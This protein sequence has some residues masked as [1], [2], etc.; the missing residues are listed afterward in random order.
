MAGESRGSG[1]H[2]PALDILGRRRAAEKSSVGWNSGQDSKR[3]Y[4]GFGLGA[5]AEKYPRYLFLPFSAISDAHEQ[6]WQSRGCAVAEKCTRTKSALARHRREG[7]A[8]G[9]CKSRRGA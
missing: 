8:Q 5:R 1:L 6:A 7:P 3:I 2:Q 4:E 9:L